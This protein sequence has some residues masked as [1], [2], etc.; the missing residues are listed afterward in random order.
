MNL[1]YIKL[2]EEIKIETREFPNDGH[3]LSTRES[4]ILHDIFGKDFIHDFTIKKDDG[5]Y[6]LEEHDYNRNR[7]E[8][9]R[10]ESYGD[11]IG[12]LFIAFLI[13]NCYRK[14]DKI[15]KVLEHP[16]ID[17]SVNGNSAI[18]IAIAL[19]HTELVKLLLKDPR[20]DPNSSDVIEFANKNGN[21]EII[22]LLNQ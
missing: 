4:Q 21:M 14:I 10:F 18:K 12:Y 7:S 8:Y 11:L 20:V 6:Y 15:S 1:K 13:L 9:E 2:F 17:P 3:D 16:K 22:K 19:G 5:Y